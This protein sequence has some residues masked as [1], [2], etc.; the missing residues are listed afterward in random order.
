[1][2]SNSKNEYQ[3]MLKQSKPF[4]ALMLTFFL[5]TLPV[6][7]TSSEIA[8]LPL[9]INVLEHRNDFASQADSK[10]QDTLDS[11]TIRLIPRNQVETYV[12]YNTTW[13]PPVKIL[14]AI[15]DATQADYIA[16]GNLTV[17]GK[18]ISVDVKLF[19]ILSPNAPT[20]YS[21]TAQSTDEL[22]EV[23]KSIAAEI[24]AYT[25]RDFR[26]ASIAPEGNTRID[27]GAILRKI[28]TKEG[29][30]YDPTV[31]RNDLKAIYKMG[32]FNDVQIDVIDTPKGKKVTFKVIEKP[33]IQAVTFEGIDELNEEDVP[34]TS[35]STLSSILRRSV[36]P[37]RQYTSCTRPRGSI[38]VK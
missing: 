9:N 26:I 36:L 34:P 2:I 19:D 12:E 11:T 14:Q 17:I 6:S 37:K 27:S 28:T 25:E 1:M 20:Y 8:F 32:Y 29:D 10:L 24:Q 35:K 5:L 33:V 15:A 13:P 30:T 7:A 38:T 18:Q 31:L 21:Q 16:A 23:L 4:Y 3:S 22:D